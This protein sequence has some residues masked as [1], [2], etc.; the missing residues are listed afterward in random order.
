LLEWLMKSGDSATSLRDPWLS[1]R[2][3]RFSEVGF[4]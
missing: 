3:W 1:A 4:H 2:C